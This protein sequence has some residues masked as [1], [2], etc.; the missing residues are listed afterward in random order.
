MNTIGPEMDPHTEIDDMFGSWAIPCR[1]NEFRGWNISRWTSPLADEAIDRAKRTID[2]EERRAAYATVMEEVVRD[3]PHIYLYSRS[4][5][6][7]HHED[8]RGPVSNI[9]EYLGWNA[10]E[11]HWVKQRR[12][13]H[14]N[15]PRNESNELVA[16]RP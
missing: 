5:I 16:A 15:K 12:R 8:L 3:R 11:W 7:A 9:W 2:R 10:L 14:H 1:E 6:Y 4:T 13:I